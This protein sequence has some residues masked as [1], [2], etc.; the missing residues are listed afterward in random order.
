MTSRPVIADLACLSLGIRL[1]TY[2]IVFN[3]LNESRLLTL[4]SSP[5]NY[6]LLK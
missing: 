2:L 3:V 4:S 1:I 6:A 5:T